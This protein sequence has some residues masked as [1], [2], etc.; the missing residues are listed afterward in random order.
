MIYKVMTGQSLFD[1]Y[2][3]SCYVISSKWMHTAC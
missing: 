1:C 3:I 2:V